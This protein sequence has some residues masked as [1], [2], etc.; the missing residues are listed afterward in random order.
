M[1][2]AIRTIPKDGLPLEYQ[3]DPTPLDLVE[4]GIGFDGPIGVRL[5][6]TKQDETVRLAGLVEAPAVLR[7]V[8]C[9]TEFRFPLR[10]PVSAEYTPKPLVPAPARSEEYG[11]TREELD[12]RY[13]E[14]EELEA[15][16]L[17]REQI[18]LSFPMHPLCRPDCRGLCPSCGQDLNEGSCGC[19]KEGP[20][21]LR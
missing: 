4:E 1:R 19:T 7:C 8:R 14:G 16:D 6:V 13:Y 10:L 21:T 12:V 5:R 9:L 20:V 2:V 11:L 17:V 3:A 18:L 15:D